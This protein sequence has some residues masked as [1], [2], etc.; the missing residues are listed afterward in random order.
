MTWPAN[1]LRIFAAASS[2][3][4]DARSKMVRLPRLAG[5]LPKVEEMP[6]QRD[7]SCAPFGLSKIRQPEIELAGARE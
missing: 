5:P 2:L 6:D 7:A 3:V 1:I 4:A